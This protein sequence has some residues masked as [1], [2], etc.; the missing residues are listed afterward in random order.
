MAKVG[1]HM[2]RG[3]ALGLTEVEISLTG[4]QEL[5]YIFKVVL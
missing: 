4:D 5:C 3:L 1:G 2:E